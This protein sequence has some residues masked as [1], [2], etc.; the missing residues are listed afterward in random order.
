MFSYQRVA[1]SGSHA[2]AATSARGRAIS[3]SVTTS[4]ATALR[5]QTTRELHAPAHVAARGSVEPRLDASGTEMA[6]ED[7]VRTL[8]ESLV[9]RHQA[10]MPRGTPRRSNSAGCSGKPVMPEI[11]VPTMANTMTP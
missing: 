10:E 6:G 11:L 2:N 8:R 3:I 4:T 9:E 5:G 7:R 1:L